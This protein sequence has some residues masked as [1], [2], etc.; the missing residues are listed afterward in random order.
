MLLVFLRFE[1]KQKAMNEE[2]E[3]EVII[4][5]LNFISI[6][7]HKYKKLRYTYNMYKSYT[8]KKKKEEICY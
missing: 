7:L 4:Y 6:Y 3:K 5:N 1:K 2:S 8:K